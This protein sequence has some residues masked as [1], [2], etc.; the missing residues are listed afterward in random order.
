[1]SRIKT[2]LRVVATLLT[3]VAVTGCGT[4]YSGKPHMNATSDLQT[5][6]IVLVGRIELVPPLSAEEQ[7]LKT[8]T[9]DRFQGRASGLF[10]ERAFDL[11]NL[12]MS[13]STHAILL[14]MG[15]EFYA[16]QPKSSEIIYSGS[17]VLMRSAAHY[18]GYMGR[19]VTI[20]HRQLNLP[21][22]IKYTLKP[23]D[24][25]VYIGTIR[26][27]RDDYNAITKVDL[28]NDHKRVNK[29]FVS[30]FGSGLKLRYVKPEKM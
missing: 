2:L 29:E 5:N 3:V 16:R 13:A 22:G 23:D 25:A 14:D 17:V 4:M 18:G 9:S 15:T 30:R 7:E 11:N 21:G 1:V 19:N 8:L 28:I 6:E 26:Y 27:Y 12:P 10:S 20:D 24:R